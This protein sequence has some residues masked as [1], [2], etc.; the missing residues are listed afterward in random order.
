[1]NHT[2]CISTF[3]IFLI[4]Q[5]LT[6]IVVQSNKTNQTLK[7]GTKSGLFIIKMIYI[8]LKLPIS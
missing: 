7:I 3:L 6:G 2:F 4:A 1:M 5:S 8:G